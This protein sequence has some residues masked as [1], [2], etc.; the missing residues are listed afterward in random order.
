MTTRLA[1]LSILAGVLAVCSPVLA[2]HGNAALRRIGR[3][4]QERHRDKAIVGESHTIVRIRREG[5]QGTRPY[6]GQPE[7][8]AALRHWA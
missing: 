5:R 6:T 3:R 2:H 8:S 1:A 4:A 7:S